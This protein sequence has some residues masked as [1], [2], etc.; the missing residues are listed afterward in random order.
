MENLT[1]FFMG[2]LTM[3][4]AVFDSIPKGSLDMLCTTQHG[5]GEKW[6]LLPLEDRDV[7]VSR[8]VVLFLVNF[9]WEKLGSPHKMCV[10]MAQ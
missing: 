5:L 6:C 1:V 2:K 10:E 7:P 9:L 8:M 3:S 4:M